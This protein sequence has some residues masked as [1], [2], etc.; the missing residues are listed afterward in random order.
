MFCKYCGSKISDDSVFCENCGKRLTQTDD[1]NIKNQSE[2][3]DNAKKN[4][5]VEEP[6]EQPKSHTST[7]KNLRITPK[8][9][10]N[11]LI[12]SITICIFQG[13]VTAKSFSDLSKYQRIAAGMRYTPTASWEQNNLYGLSPSD[14][15]QKQAVATAWDNVY[16][17]Q[18]TV[19]RNCILLTIFLAFTIVITI[20]Y[21]RSKRNNC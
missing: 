2:P 15:A 3:E 17:A 1:I 12:A 11:I 6:D 8:L 16:F 21:N 13:I 9:I 18:A 5:S 7:K 20:S 4:K 14:R 10:R 19:K